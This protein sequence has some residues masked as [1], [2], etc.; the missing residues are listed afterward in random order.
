MG[1]PRELVQYIKGPRHGR[2]HTLPPPALHSRQLTACNS[3]GEKVAPDSLL[4]LLLMANPS[5]FRLM[6]EPADLVSM[7]FNVDSTQSPVYRSVQLVSQESIW[8]SYKAGMWPK[9]GH[10]SHT[11]LVTCATIIIWK[12]EPNPCLQETLVIPSTFQDISY[13]LISVHIQKSISRLAL[14]EHIT[15]SQV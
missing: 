4:L 13:F 14:S 3:Q 9:A 5:D 10:T 15:R 8:V 11:A 12:S 1:Y 7:S 6:I 2:L